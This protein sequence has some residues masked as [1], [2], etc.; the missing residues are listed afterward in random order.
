M[1][2][3][4]GCSAAPAYRGLVFLPVRVQKYRGSYRVLHTRYAERDGLCNCADCIWRTGW[5]SICRVGTGGPLPRLT[6]G[7]NLRDRHW[8]HWRISYLTS[9][10][11]IRDG[12]VSRGSYCRLAGASLNGLYVIL[13][14]RSCRAGDCPQPLLDGLRKDT[15]HATDREAVREVD[16][17]TAGGC[18]DDLEEIGIVH[19]RTQTR[20]DGA[21][22]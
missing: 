20:R 5:D 6:L 16:D 17:R 12:E 9:L 3:S 13:G 19:T 1:A 21:C 10:Q 22:E 15:G 2:V 7:G 4:V 11:G 8:R 14:R 18:G